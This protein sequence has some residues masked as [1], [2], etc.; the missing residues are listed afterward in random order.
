M[1]RSALLAWRRPP[2]WITNDSTNEFRWSESWPL[3]PFICLTPSFINPVRLCYGGEPP[4]YSHIEYIAEVNLPA[5][6]LDDVAAEKRLLAHQDRVDRTAFGL[7]T[8]ATGDAPAKK[9]TKANAAT[10]AKDKRSIKEKSGKL[11]ARHK[12][13][14]AEK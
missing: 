11:K 12:Q 1:N 6:I 4:N 9:V 5:A 14:K 13:K 2:T 3:T 10:T 8:A 7:W